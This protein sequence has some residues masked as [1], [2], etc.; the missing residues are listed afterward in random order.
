MYMPDGEE[1]GVRGLNTSL[2][3]Q[4]TLKFKLSRGNAGKY[5]NKNKIH[6]M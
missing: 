6:G 2:D 1:E 5:K 3:F 4:K